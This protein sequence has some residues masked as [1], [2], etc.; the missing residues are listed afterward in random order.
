MCLSL[1]FF[2]GPS[3]MIFPKTFGVGSSSLGADFGGDCEQFVS[4]YFVYD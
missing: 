1:V 4:P 3:R 2:G